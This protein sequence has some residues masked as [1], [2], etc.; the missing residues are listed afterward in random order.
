MEELEVLAETQISVD[1][2]IKK[3]FDRLTVKVPNSDLSYITLDSF[4]VA[5]GQM[6]NTAF[7]Q[8]AVNNMQTVEAVMDNIFK[9][10]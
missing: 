5:I 8:G 9:K 1:E 2:Q 4:K 6:M 3:L 10:N 7:H